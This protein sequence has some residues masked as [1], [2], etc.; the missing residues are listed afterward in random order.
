MEEVF[1]TVEIPKWVKCK[2]CEEEVLIYPS[3]LNGEEYICP[4]CK[5][6]EKGLNKG[7]QTTERKDESDVEVVFCKRH[8][9]RKVVH[10]GWSTTC[11]YLCPQCYDT[12][13]EE[14]RAE[15]SPSQTVKPREQAEWV[16]RSQYKDLI[17]TTTIRCVWCKK[18]VPCFSDW[19]KT[20]TTLCPSCYQEAKRIQQEEADKAYV[21]KVIK[22]KSVDS[23]ERHEG[24]STRTLL[25][26]T[27]K[28]LEE[29]V[30]KG[31]VSKT[32]YKIE[33]RRRQKKSYYLDV[34]DGVNDWVP[35]SE[36][37]LL[38]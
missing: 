30:K 6:E 33:K 32:R 29:A 26:A 19:L 35:C 37:D 28:E 24:W 8:R 34:G 31:W 12:L 14:E 13:T 25:R 11:S 10:K 1:A 20:S 38:D 9:E 15:Y 4:R 23:I 3:E 17:P 5:R 18:E 27:D 21:A 22:A 36:G 2:G 7:K 16:K